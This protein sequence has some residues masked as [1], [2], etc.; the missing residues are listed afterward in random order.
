MAT[1]YLHKNRNELDII[2]CMLRISRKGATRTQL[3][4]RANLSFKLLELYL[5]TLL[6][7][8]M[9]EICEENPRKSYHINQRGR[10]FLEHY[11]GL[12]KLMFP[13]SDSSK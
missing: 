4:Y 8:N 3:M 12:K 2:A 1:I 13:K 11:H 7:L 6:A 9:V 5:N 10:E